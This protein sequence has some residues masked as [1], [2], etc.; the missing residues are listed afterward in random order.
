MRVLVTGANGQ[1]GQA[2]QSTCPAAVDIT[3]LTRS[4]LD[5]GD[6]NA[7]RTAIEQLRPDWVLNAAAY[8]AV[9]RAEKEPELARAINETA[10]KHQA[11]ASRAAGARLLHVSTDFVF[12]G[13]ERRPYQPDDPTAPLNVYGVTKRDGET[14]ALEATAE[15]AVVVRTAWVYSRTGRNF[16]TTMMRLMRER[17]SLKIV[18]DQRGAPTA[19]ADLA[20]AIW[21]LIDAKPA[22][23]IYHYTNSGEATWYEFAQAIHAA[24]QAR[25]PETPLAQ[26]EPTDTAGFPTPAKRPTY[27]VLDCQKIEA[28]IGKRRPWQDALRNIMNST[29]F[30]RS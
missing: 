9:D 5:I 3:A 26:I 2:L 20:N 22:G 6:S 4:D 13:K 14:A 25:E 19:T 30:E 24:L 17:E 29:E 8:T 11:Q 23:G 16:L 15:D 10:V 27:S 1:L 7:I 18:D 12:D 28:F 21:T